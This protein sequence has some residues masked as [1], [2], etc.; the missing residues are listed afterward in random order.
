MKRYGTSCFGKVDR[1]IA[2][3]AI[4]LLLI[5]GAQVAYSQSRIHYAGKNIFINGINIAWVNFAGDIG[6]NAPNL[7]Q[8]QTEFQTVHDNGGNV[9][10]FWLHT[11]GSQTPLFDGNGYVSG[12]GPVAIQ[13]LKQ[14]LNLAQQNDIGLILCLWS[15]DMLNQSELDTAQLHRNAKMLTDTAYTNVYIRKALIP[16]VDSLKGHPAIVAW[17]IFNE[18][19]GITNEFGWSGRDHV[20]MAAI[21]QFVNLTT[22]AIHRTDK[23]ILV[24]SGAVTFQTLTDVNSSS[25]NNT[26]ELK[27]IH[28]MSAVQQK[29]LVN[30]FNTRHRLRMTVEEYLVYVGKLAAATNINYYRDDRLIA[31]AGD[32]AGTLDFYCVHYYAQ[33]HSLSPFVHPASYWGLNK[34]IVA[35]EFYTQSTDGLAGLSLYPWL[36]DNGYAGGMAWSWT[37]FGNPPTNSEADTWLSLKYIFDNHRNDIIINPK[38]GSI[39]AF[40]VSQMTIQKTDRY[41]F[42]VGC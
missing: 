32:S 6:P 42:E 17:E 11:N 28:S 24:T 19:E 21:Q 16:M 22:G 37:D 26:A 8:F 4:L 10:R 1:A 3:C 18:P 38:T 5:T 13:N 29:N 12:P 2:S 20:P 9:M 14:I 30:E 33:G 25:S 34:P 41:S 39:Y 7:A 23:S 15:H 36:Y 27:Q 35:A 31:A 40:S